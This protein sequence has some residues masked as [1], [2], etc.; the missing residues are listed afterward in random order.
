[1]THP[2]P[3][4]DELRS[5]IEAHYSLR[6]DASTPL[7]GGEEATIWQVN[8]SHGL[9]VEHMSPA[10]LCASNTQPFVPFFSPKRAGEGTRTVV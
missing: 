6:L 5:A 9:L 3:L 2:D 10:R 8:A 1:M 7:L 4:A